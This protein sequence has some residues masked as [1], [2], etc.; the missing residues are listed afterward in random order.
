[1]TTYKTCIVKIHKQNASE[2]KNISLFF[3]PS[4]KDSYYQNYTPTIPV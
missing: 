3:K 4:I 1:M 2:I